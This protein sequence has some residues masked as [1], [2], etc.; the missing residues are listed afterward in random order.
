MNIKEEYRI[1]VKTVKDSAA[2][3]GRKLRNEDIAKRLG[4]DRA[5]FSTLT[6]NTG[7]V[8][9]EHLEEFKLHFQEELFDEVKAKP[10]DTLNP[11]RALLLAI[12]EDYATRISEITRIDADVVK[13]GVLRRATSILGGL[14][15][16]PFHD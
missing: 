11:E 1:L 8:T 5:Y 12:L 14:D 16:W 13:K 2:K 4:Y 7:K 6:G 9:K 3:R 10:G 15:E